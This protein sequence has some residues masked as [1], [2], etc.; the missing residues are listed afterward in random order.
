MFLKNRK[1][2]YIVGPKIWGSLFILVPQFKQSIFFFKKK[3]STFI[4][5]KMSIGRGNTKFTI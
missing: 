1:K 4:I 2:T 3:E 5:L